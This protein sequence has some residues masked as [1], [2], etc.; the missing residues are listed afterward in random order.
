M[1]ILYSSISQNGNCDWYA[2]TQLRARAENQY[3]LR[4]WD[5]Y[6]IASGYYVA[7]VPFKLTGISVLIV[8]THLFL[9]L[10]MTHEPINNSTYLGRPKE[11]PKYTP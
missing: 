4:K 7:N 10:E 8:F 3:A 2:N 11:F 6:N 1:C 9:A 5:S